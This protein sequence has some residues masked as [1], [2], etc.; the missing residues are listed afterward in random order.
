MSAPHLQ[1][2]HTGDR[3]VDRAVNAVVE[4][5]GTIWRSDPSLDGVVHRAVRISDTDPTAI[6]HK[7]GRAYVGWR[8]ERVYPSSTLTTPGFVLEMSIERRDTHL[9]LRTVGLD[10]PI[11]VDLRV[12]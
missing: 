1:R 10:A 3:D 8:I 9:E 5:M 12:W 11:F 4:D 7:L 6:P 2:A